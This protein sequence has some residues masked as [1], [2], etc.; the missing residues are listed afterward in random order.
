MKKGPEGCSACHGGA[1]RERSRCKG[2]FVRE[3]S[4]TVLGSVENSGR[5]KLRANKVS[6]ISLLRSYTHKRKGGGEVRS[7]GAEE[8]EGY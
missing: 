3:S 1:L 8:E 7:S 5:G 6:C 4:F 2:V